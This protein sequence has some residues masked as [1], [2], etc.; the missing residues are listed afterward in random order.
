[1]TQ[2]STITWL[3]LL[4]AIL[5]PSSSVASDTALIEFLDVGQ[6][7]AILV[8]TPEAKTMLV[9]AGPS[10]KIVE[11]LQR[12]GLS[13][14]D[15][16]VISHHHFDHYG[17][18][19]DVINNFE[20]RNIL[21]TNAPHT[22]QR[23][24]SLLRLIRDKEIRVLNP[25]EEGRTLTL[26]SVEVIVFP[27]R[28]TY[29]GNENNNSIGLRVVHGDVSVLLTG[30]SEPSLHRWWLQNVSSALYADCSILKVPHHGSKNGLNQE[31]LQVVNPQLA[32]ISVGS[33]N[34]YGHPDSRVVSMLHDAGATLLR[35]DKDGTVAVESD[36][37][38]WRLVD[39]S[40]LARGPPV[41]TTSVES[42]RTLGVGNLVAAE[43]LPGDAAVEEIIVYVT[44]TGKKYHTRS[45][46]Y[47]KRSNR[48]LTLDE[49]RRKYDPCKI[50]KPPQ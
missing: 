17:G 12:R 33:G 9:D 47:G 42:G 4:L 2:R 41:V 16:M 44:R 31:W 29:F 36:G 20:V 13:A 35:T 10:G 40:K 3:F 25:G 18:M 21:V 43:T 48:P 34:R 23:L 50:C 26:G 28:P 46:R 22:T 32:V 45:C 30:D 15:L 38:G 6:G 5:L 24:V 39:G 8:T 37:K 11:K 49:A 1:M 19:D 27:R 14:I 7:D